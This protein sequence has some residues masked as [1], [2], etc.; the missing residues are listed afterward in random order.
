MVK[1]VVGASYGEFHQM[2]VSQA[3]EDIRSL[4]WLPDL[5]EYHTPGTYFK[6]FQNYKN[7]YLT[8]PRIRFGG[9]YLMKESYVRVGVKINTQQYDPYHY[10]EFYRYMRFFPDGLVIA[11]LSCNKLSTEKLKKY[12]SYMPSQGDEDEF[13]E[14]NQ[15]IK[16]VSFGEYIVKKSIVSIRM[17]SKTTI[18]EYELEIGSSSEGMFDQL[19][20]L[21]QDL[22]IVGNPE[23]TPIKTDRM[24]TKSLSFIKINELL[25]DLPENYSSLY[26]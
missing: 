12:F 16:S 10:I 1:H 20:L 17:C 15:G 11:C 26:M 5:K 6:S 22:R 2:V 4:V 18:F 25:Q 19:T 24:E 13:I 23:K 8:A 21:S 7:M 14:K 9:V 3:K